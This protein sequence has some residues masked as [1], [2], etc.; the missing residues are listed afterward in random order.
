[1][2]LKCRFLFFL[3]GWNRLLLCQTKMKLLFETG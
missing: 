3:K 2:H 1:L